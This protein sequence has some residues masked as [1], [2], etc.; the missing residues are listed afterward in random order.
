MALPLSVPGL[1]CGPDARGQNQD[2]EHHHCDH[3]GDVQ[4]HVDLVRTC[5]TQRLNERRGCTGGAFARAKFTEAEGG[6]ASLR[7]LGFNHADRSGSK[8]E[9]APPH[10][11][12]GFRPPDPPPA[13]SFKHG[14][15]QRS[16]R[17]GAVF[18]PRCWFSSCICLRLSLT[19]ELFADADADLWT[20][21]FVLFVSVFVQIQ[22]HNNP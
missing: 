21:G 22:T 9:P 19:A 1:A 17:G 2:V 18:T 8:S 5:Q 15:G 4:S 10:W 11:V 7:P 6:G 20:H 14:T 3:T 12:N 13:Q 16:R